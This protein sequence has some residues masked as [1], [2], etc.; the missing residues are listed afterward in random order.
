MTRT[1]PSNR[2]QLRLLAVA[3]AALACLATAAGADAATGSTTS[4]NWSG[5]AAHGAGG[6][7]LQLRG[8]CDRAEWRD[9]QKRR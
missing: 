7:D 2:L 8:A 6:N 9:D 3:S 5:Y 1:G 4:A